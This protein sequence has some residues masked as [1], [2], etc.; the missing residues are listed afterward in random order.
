MSS[1]KLTFLI[2][3]FPRL[4]DNLDANTKGR[5]GKMNVQQM[6]EHFSDSVR[7]ANGKVRREIVTEPDKLP[8]YKNFVMSEKEFRP[9]TKNP[10]MPAEPLPVRNSS[11][12]KAVDELREE[13]R[14]FVAHFTA[15]PESQNASPVFGFMNYEEWI[16][17]L[18]K[19][20]VHHLKQFGVEIR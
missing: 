6:I 9:D 14:D 11:K 4:L 20:A 13:L 19:H 8:L 1:G 3:E 16:Q 12:E 7:E 18:H 5:W 17:L 2:E 10:V 15:D